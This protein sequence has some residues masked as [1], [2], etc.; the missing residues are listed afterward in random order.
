MINEELDQ[1]ALEIAPVG[2]R[3]VA[4]DWMI[5]EFA[6]RYRKAMLERMKPVAFVNLDHLEAKGIK[7][8]TSFKHSF[9]QTPLYSLEDWKK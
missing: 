4:P 8:A 9:E 1:L 2:I 5:L 6:D 3:D 7:Y